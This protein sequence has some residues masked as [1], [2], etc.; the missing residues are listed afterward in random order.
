MTRFKLY[1]LPLQIPSCRV[2]PWSQTAICTV[3]QH[4]TADLEAVQGTCTGLFVWAHPLNMK[5]G[6]YCEHTC[7]QIQINMKTNIKKHLQNKVLWWLKVISNF[8]QLIFLLFAQMIKDVLEMCMC[9]AQFYF[10]CK[11]KLSFEKKRA[12]THIKN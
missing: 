9:L 8:G 3:C 7:N 11:L 2:W 10:E 6:L 12:S 5:P 4:R 1:G